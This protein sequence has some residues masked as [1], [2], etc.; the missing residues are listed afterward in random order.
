MKIVNAN[1]PCA[2]CTACCKGDAI[3]IHPELGDDTEAYQTVPHFMPQLAAKG[4]RMLAHDANRNCVYLGEA[5]CTIHGRAPALCREFDCRKMAKRLGHT[6]ARKLAKKGVVD[7]TVIRMGLLR[8]D[9]LTTEEK[10]ACSFPK[11]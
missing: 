11:N 1:V 2:G 7:M 9:S 4:V 8:M 3:S 10:K 5:G 6:R